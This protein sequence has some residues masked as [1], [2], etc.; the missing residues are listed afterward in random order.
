MPKPHRK[1]NMLMVL[2]VDGHYR[3][4]RKAMQ[5]ERSKYCARIEKM[6]SEK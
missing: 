3:V 4:N 1:W 6:E 5:K 2:A